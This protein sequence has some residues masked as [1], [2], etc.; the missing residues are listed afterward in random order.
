[1]RDPFF[2]AAPVAGSGNRREPRRYIPGLRNVT[3]LMSFTI[4]R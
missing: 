3:R 2:H 1:M 4:T